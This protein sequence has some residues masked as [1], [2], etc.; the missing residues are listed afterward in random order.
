M[1]RYWS[2]AGLTAALLGVATPAGGVQ[3]D[4]CSN[5][6][7][8][9][10]RL[11]TEAWR[12]EDLATPLTD[13]LD[14]LCKRQKYADSDPNALRCYATATSLESCPAEPGSTWLNDSLQ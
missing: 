6:A 10:A 13:K 12:I 3:E 1:K 9:V 8:N 11:Y 14:E 4:L 5:A 7:A 2:I